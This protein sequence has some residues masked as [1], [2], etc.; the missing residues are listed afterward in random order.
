MSHQ[1]QLGYIVPAT[2]I[3]GAA[4][5]LCKTHPLAGSVWQ[6]LV[7]AGDRLG[8]WLP[9]PTK[10]LSLGKFLDPLVD[11]LLVLLPYWRWLN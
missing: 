3:T 10:L 2:G 9:S 1:A 5:L 4:V 11:K 7:A 6:F 8:R